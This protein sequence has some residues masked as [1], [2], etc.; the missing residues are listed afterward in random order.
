[1][2]TPHAP[3]PTMTHTPHQQRELRVLKDLYKEGTAKYFELVR[4]MWNMK[5]KYMRIELEKELAMVSEKN[6]IYDWL[7]S[8]FTKQAPQPI[9]NQFPIGETETVGDYTEIKEIEYDYEPHKH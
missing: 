6:K 4:Y 5:S 7:I 1:M 2:M 3:T 8:E 9:M